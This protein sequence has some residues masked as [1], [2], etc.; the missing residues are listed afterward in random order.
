ML[1]ALA[2]DIFIRGDDGAVRQAAACAALRAP[3]FEARRRRRWVPSTTLPT[4]TAASPQ[5]PQACCGVRRQACARH[6][7]SLLPK[8][9]LAATPAHSCTHARARRRGGRAIAET[10]Q[11]KNRTPPYQH[12]RHVFKLKPCQVFLVQS[13]ASIPAA[14][15]RSIDRSE[16]QQQQHA[17]RR[18]QHD[19]LVEGGASLSGPL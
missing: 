3:R 16:Q 17:Q 13:T 6:H 5:H 11:N 2:H 15:S 4:P 7:T 1:I 8:L 19:G 10:S 18:Q 9:A 14:S 12:K